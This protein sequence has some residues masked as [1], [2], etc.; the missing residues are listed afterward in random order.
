MSGGAVQQGDEADEAWSTS[1]LRSL[2]PVFGG[3]EVG[4]MQRTD[5]AGYRVAA[6]LAALAVCLTPAAA[7]EPSFSSALRE[8]QE[9]THAEPLKSY[10]DGPFNQAFYSR[11]SGW[12]N[13]CTQRTGQRFADFDLLIRVGA[14]GTVESVRFEPKSAPT[15]CFVGLLK[16]EALPVPPKVPLVVPI[17]IR[18]SGK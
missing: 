9:A 2:S 1:E 12:I 14:K 13:E 11:F 15:E 18:F 7:E 5:L 4:K 8:A 10:V 3:R 6:V 16:A 17:G